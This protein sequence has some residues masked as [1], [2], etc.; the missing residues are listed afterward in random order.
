VLAAAGR[1][2]GGTRACFSVSIQSIGRRMAGVEVETKR[3]SL[4]LEELS[5]GVWLPESASGVKR[6]PEGVAIAPCP[7]GKDGRGS[8]VGV[9]G[10]E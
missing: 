1:C 5:A 8:R 4:K 6:L 3:L 9:G 10:W 2:L 7:V